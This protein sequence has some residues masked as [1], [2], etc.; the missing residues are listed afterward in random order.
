[1]GA[2]I[3]KGRIAGDRG[4]GCRSRAG[5]LSVAVIG[6]LTRLDEKGAFMH[7]RDAI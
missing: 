1:M 4:S 2:R 3:K 6:A 7:E 5:V